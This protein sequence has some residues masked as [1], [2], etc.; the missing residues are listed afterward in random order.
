MTS[1]WRWL[2]IA[3]DRSARRFGHLLSCAAAMAMASENSG[4][5]CDETASR[6]DRHNSRRSVHDRE[7]P[8][9]LRQTR[10]L[11]LAQPRKPLQY[12]QLS[13]SPL[14]RTSSCS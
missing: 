2:W 6:M 11:L 10:H 14:F 9:D 5:C 13:S 3:D 4:A 12:R 7:P 8:I 1:P